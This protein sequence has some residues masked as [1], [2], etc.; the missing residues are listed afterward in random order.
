MAVK[1][2][3]QIGLEDEVLNDADLQDLLERRQ[4]A[5]EKTAKVRADYA[6][7]NEQAKGRVLEMELDGRTVRCGRF[8]LGVT[9]S[10]VQAVSFERRGGRRASIRL[11]KDDAA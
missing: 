4:K 1:E 8:L 2:Q 7:L 5:K 9:T 6:E 3:A 11:V 10:E